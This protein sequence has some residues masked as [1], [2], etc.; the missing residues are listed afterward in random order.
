MAGDLHYMSGFGAH[1][2]SEAVAGALPVGQNSPQKT[3]FGLYA[4]QFSAT[5]FTAPRA[6]NLRAWLYRLRPSA[7]HPAF[8]RIDD[9]RLRTGPCPEAQA[10]PNRLRWAPMAMPDGPTDFIDGLATLATNGEARL[11]SGVGVHLYSANQSM[12]RVFASFDGEL[13]LVPQEG[14]LAIATEFGHLAVAPGEIAVIPRGVKFRVAVAGPVR[15]YAC[16]NYGAPLRLPDLGPIGAN[17]LANPRDFL[18][19]VAAFE[20]RDVPTEV[21]V[22]SGGHLWTAGYG[23]SPLDVVAWHGNVHPFKYDLARFNAINTVSFDHPDPS[24]F[25]VLTS[26]SDTPGTANVDFVIFPPRWLVAEHT[27]RP[28]WFHRNVMSEFMGL[29]HG[30][31]DAKRGGFVPGGAS[32]HNAMTAHGPDR[33]SHEAAV[34]AKLDPKHLGHTLAFMFESRHPFD[35]TAFA[36]ASP[37]LE[38][39]Y[40]AAWA[41]FPAVRLAK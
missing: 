28:P 18:A 20:D 1:H 5:S 7:M 14:T 40:D 22:K 11:Q 12:E 17:G 34:A 2:E 8:R 41:G 6:R 29:V 38:K 24:I 9:G 30:E 31:Y 32:L 36:M 13:L 27:F 23:H 19:P 33:A 37:A 35:P 15:G 3:P 16:E 26:P 21:V 4:E 25:T 39:D 10:G